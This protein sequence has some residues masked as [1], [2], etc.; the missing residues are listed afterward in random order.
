MEEVRREALNCV[1]EVFETVKKKGGA[2]RGLKHLV[3]NRSFGA[4]RKAL[5]ALPTEEV[6]VAVETVFPEVMT[7]LYQ[8]DLQLDLADWAAEDFTK[9]FFGR[10]KTKYNCALL[11]EPI[12]LGT[13]AENIRAARTSQA[14]T[15]RRI[16]REKGE[17]SEGKDDDETPRKERRERRERVHEDK[18]KR[19][20][21]TP[22]PGSHREQLFLLERMLNDVLSMEA[23]E[24]E[25]AGAVAV[26]WSPDGRLLLKDVYELG[27]K[28]GLFHAQEWSD[29]VERKLSRA[30]FQLHQRRRL[31]CGDSLAVTGNSVVDLRRT[32]STAAAAAQDCKK[33]GEFDDYF[34]LLLHLLLRNF[35]YKP[36]TIGCPPRDPSVSATQAYPGHNICCVA[37]S[38]EGKLLGFDFNQCKADKNLCSH[39]EK[40]LSEAI[41]NGLKLS[42]PDGKP[43]SLEGWAFVT[44]LEPCHMC[45][46]FISRMGVRTIGFLMRDPMQMDAIFVAAKMLNLEVHRPANEGLNTLLETRFLTSGLPEDEITSW[47][48]SADCKSVLEE[49][50][51]TFPL[52]VKHQG[53]FSKFGHLYPGCALVGVAQSSFGVASDLGVVD[54]AEFGRAVSI[55]SLLEDQFNTQAGE[56]E[57]AEEGMTSDGTHA[58]QETPL[59]TATTGSP[60]KFAEL[61]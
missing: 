30:I 33:T 37:I 48:G 44:S 1:E 25:A 13:I 42:T 45:A 52:P 19:V 39:A 21:K 46:N 12:S 61:I 2:C 26:P 38:P 43:P 29:V 16:P 56:D 23:A 28:E 53:W 36:G 40:R 34:A 17:P 27:R 24:G 57:E 35:H 8:S 4:L 41:N 55:S 51:K 50:T 5:E 58:H 9:R 60:S 15:S 6:R 32:Q 22:A 31:S 18:E 49:L 7:R 47:L 54:D 10:R 20:H 14:R 11:K 59:T 3:G